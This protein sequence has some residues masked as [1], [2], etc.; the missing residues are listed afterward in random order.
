MKEFLHLKKGVLVGC[1]RLSALSSIISNICIKQTSI[2]QKGI[3]GTIAKIATIKY[4]LDT[5][6]INL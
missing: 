4:E 1:V 6:S 3:L 5:D 2:Q